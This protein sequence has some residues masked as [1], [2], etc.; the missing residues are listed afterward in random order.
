MNPRFQIG[1]KV[2]IHRSWSDLDGALGTISEPVEPV[3]SHSGFGS[4]YYKEETLLTGGHRIA[5]WVELDGT[6]DE[7]GAIEAGEFDETELEKL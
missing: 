5:Y 7:S 6:T 1:D 4:S 3:R 2:K